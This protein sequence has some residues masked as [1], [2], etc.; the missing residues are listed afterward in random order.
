V[1]EK[2]RT[3]ILVVLC[4][5]FIFDVIACKTAPVMLDTTATDLMAVDVMQTQTEIVSASKYVTATI[6]D[7][8]EITDAAKLTGVVPVTIIKYVD[9]LEAENK[10][11]VDAIKTQTII[12]PEFN[13]LRIGNNASAEKLVSEKQTQYEKEKNKA[14]I[15]LRWALTATLISLVLAGVIFLP[16]TIKCII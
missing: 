7:I 4:S 11:L 5:L 14:T 13:K 12:L 9:V 6:D 15:F 16:K 10:T 8:K 3:S 2:I 1:N